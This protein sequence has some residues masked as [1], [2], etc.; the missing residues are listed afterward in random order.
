MVISVLSIPQCLASKQQQQ[1]PPPPKKNQ[2]KLD[3]FT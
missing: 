1:Q 3:S 2:K